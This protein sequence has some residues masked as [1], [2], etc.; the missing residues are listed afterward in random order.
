MSIFGRRF[1]IGNSVSPPVAKAMT[2]A[3]LGAR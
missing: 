3:I 1:Y 2:E